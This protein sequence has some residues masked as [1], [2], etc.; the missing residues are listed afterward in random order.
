ML[1]TSLIELTY[2]AYGWTLYGYLFLLLKMSGL[3][4]LPFIFLGI[5]AL[6]QSSVNGEETGTTVRDIIANL[7]LMILIYI[8]AMPP[9]VKLELNATRINTLGCGQIEIAGNPLIPIETLSG[10]GE[11]NSIHIPIIPYLTI[12][13]S[14]TIRNYI[15]GS[16][17]CISDVSMSALAS[18]PLLTSNFDETPLLK[19]RIQEFSNQCYKPALALHNK[20]LRSGNESQRLT[21]QGILAGRFYDSDDLNEGNLFDDIFVDIYYAGQFSQLPQSYGSLACKNNPNSEACRALTPNQKA[22]AEAEKDVR[23]SLPLV[24]RGSSLGGTT[25]NLDAC[26]QSES[27]KENEGTCVD[28]IWPWWGKSTTTGKP[29]KGSI[30]YDVMYNHLQRSFQESVAKSQMLGAPTRAQI[31]VPGYKRGWFDDRVIDGVEYLNNPDTVIDNFI[32]GLSNKQLLALTDHLFINNS[33]P[34][35]GTSISSGKQTLGAAAMATGSFIGAAM[36]GNIVGTSANLLASLGS[37][38]FM[39]ETLIESLK[40]ILPMVQAFIFSLWGVI[41]LS[42]FY[43]PQGVWNAVIALFTVMLVPAAWDMADLL[44]NALYESSEVKDAGWTNISAFTGY[45]TIYVIRS[46]FYLLIPPILFAVLKAGASGISSGIASTGAVAML[47]GGLSNMA[48]SIG[49]TRR[50]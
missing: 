40:I 16:I 43:R 11:W 3:I 19:E 28:C 47:A 31:S 6:V 17:P 49:G 30:A 25:K 50:K 5:N 14:N 48:R 27:Q 36:S 9:L 22:Y 24:Y 33:Q 26:H 32:N 15:R 42:V 21:Y 13:V 18:T 23:L 37:T 34:L 10:Q 38:L 7:V 44:T 41:I 20:W 1:T 12:Q 35:E 46:I 45:L 4:L 2:T 29:A 8:L 39:I